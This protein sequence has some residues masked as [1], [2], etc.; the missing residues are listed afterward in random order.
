MDQEKMENIIRFSKRRGFIFPGS[1]LYGGLAGTWDYG[2]LGFRLKE[3]IRRAWLSFFV[4]SRDDVHAIDAPILLHPKVWETSGHLKEFTD[5]LVDC[6]HCKGRFRADHIE[7]TAC[8]ECGKEELTEARPFNM[9]FKTWIGP[10]EEKSSEAY[11]RPENAQGI[12]I[13]FKNVMDTL[14]PKLPFGI[15]Q[16]GKV[17]RNEISP[18]EFLFRTREFEL[19]EFEY[20]V[21]EK[22]WKKAFEYWSEEMMKWTDIL[23][24]SRKKLHANDLP[25]GERAHYSSRTID[26][27][28]EYPFGVKELMAIAYRGDYD[29]NLHMEGSSTDIRYFDEETK[30]HELPH[31]VEPTF[32]L[33][34]AFLAVLAESYA[35]EQVKEKD[36]RT[37]LK[38]PKKL[39]PY[40]V[41][42]FPLVSNKENIVKKARDVYEGLR[43]DMSAAWDDIGN[44]G[45]RYRRQDEIG[46]PWCI[47]VDYDT[48]EDGTVT[49]RDRDTMEQERI[50]A[51]AI[52]S[53]IKEK[54]G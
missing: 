20:F 45:K 5:P 26:F 41:A 15:A 51:D 38:L 36:V 18:G 9:L 52:A 2:P 43:K 48:L 39:A 42:I 1:S 35:E 37:V 29:M 49:V 13:N 33:D 40:Q 21:H 25:D 30:T 53:Y 23:G 12:F 34:R 17:F 28:Y 6:K 44:I 27:E 24:L 10:L 47:T 31:V 3:N 32:G 50:P 19:M 8:P 7:G 22:G 54:L 16:V 4:D 14:H 11:L 46:T